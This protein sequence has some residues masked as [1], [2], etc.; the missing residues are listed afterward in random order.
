MALPGWLALPALL[1]LLLTPGSG[2]A[3]GFA[4]L[5]TDAEGYARVTPPAALAFPRDHAPHPGFRI[6]WWYVT[7]TLTGADGTPYGAQ[8]T[9]FRQALSPGPADD[10]WESPELWMAHAAVTT[11]TEHHAAE[12]FAR[13]GIGQADVT[14]APFR[15]WIDDWQMI[16]R[17][18]QGDA[19]ATLELR[20]GG[21]DFAYDLGLATAHAPVAQG[22]RGFSVK[23]E[24]GQASYYYSQP[25]YEVT[26]TITL[27]GAPIPVT[28]QAWL[29]R[30]WSSQPLDSDQE[31]WDWFALHLDGGEK[32]MLYRLR[33]ATGPAFLAGTWIAA[34]GT[35]TPLAP[36]E[37]VAEPRQIAE[38]AGREIPVGWHLEVPGRGLAVDTE[39]LN[40]Q[41][42]MDTAYAYWE[43]PIRFSGSHSGRGYQE[44]TGY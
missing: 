34:D 32:L 25:F 7:A 14:L 36:D 15:A 31:G 29:D 2:Q 18:G 5:G 17:D 22:D 35:P 41:S 43:G 24:R 13:G 4:G 30:E 11:P 42:W 16:G 40:A 39:A 20:A 12:T 26:G 6:E 10:G 1:A 19:L 9:L 21:D 44:L 3:Q 23:S 28:G 33:H 8:W 38:V 37:I 27:D